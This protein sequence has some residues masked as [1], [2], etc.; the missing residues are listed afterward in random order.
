MRRKAGVIRELDFRTIWLCD[1]REL[2]PG[3][4]LV[5][6]WLANFC[7][8][9]RPGNGYFCRRSKPHRRSS[10]DGGD[11][12]YALSRGLIKKCSS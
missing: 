6:K 2:F 1:M 10:R 12:K 7:V 5:I 8:V 3:V 11:V 9:Y 4:F